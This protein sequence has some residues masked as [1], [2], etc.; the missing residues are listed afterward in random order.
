[1]PGPRKKVRTVK[2]KAKRVQQTT[3]P[4]LA[5]LEDMSIAIRPLGDEIDTVRG[6]Y[7]EAFDHLD[8]AQ[9]SLVDALSALRGL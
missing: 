6:V 9:M 7:E 1:M 3:P 2:R 8:Q 5:K 4:L